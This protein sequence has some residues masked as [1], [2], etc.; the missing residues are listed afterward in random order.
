MIFRFRLI[1]NQLKLL[2]IL[3][4]KENV[5]KNIRKKFLPGSHHNQFSHIFVE[6][7]LLPTTSR[8]CRT[9]YRM[10]AKWISAGTMDI[11]TQTSTH[12]AQTSCT[13]TPPATNPSRTTIEQL[14]VFAWRC[15][16]CAELFVQPS[17]ASQFII[18]L[19]VSHNH[20]CIHTR[21]QRHHCRSVAVGVGS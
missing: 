4:I 17:Q 3:N 2:V 7:R 6:S 21:E 15:V 13:K 20:T 10:C 11:H 16:V 5:N 19:V 14:R 8:L 12:S 1:T 18:G 9:S